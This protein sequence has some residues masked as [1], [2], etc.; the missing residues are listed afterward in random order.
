M[1][2]AGFQTHVE[3]E[4]LTAPL[5]GEH[6]PGHFR[7]VTT[8]VAKLFGLTGPCLAVFGRK[9]YQ[10]WKVL[11]RMTRD[12]DL[13]VEIH[14]HPTI[15][16]SDGL[17]LSSRNRYLSVEERARALAI[18]RGLRGARGAFAGGDR[19]ASA[20][21]A[22]VRAPIERA[23]DSIDYVAAVD[24]ETLLAPADG[25]ANTRLLIAVAARIGTTRLIDNTVLGED[26]PTLGE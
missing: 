11:A 20:L 23:F 13:P 26:D 9:D 7:G 8:V 10:Q 25:S 3:V 6:R 12:L 14:G 18:S 2:P 16:E 21:A 4:G 24:P 19:N 1:Y 5:E 15:R 17:A 22:V